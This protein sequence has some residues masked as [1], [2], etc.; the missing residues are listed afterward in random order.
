QLATYINNGYSAAEAVY[1]SDQV[2]L[3]LANGYDDSMFRWFFEGV[4]SAGAKWD[5]IGMSHYPPAASWASYNSQIS[6]TTSDMI[7]R[8]GKPV[9][10]SEVEMDWTQASTAK[11][12]LS[13]LISKTKAF[14][15]NGL[16]IFYW[17]PKA[18]PGW[19]S[20][21]LGAIDAICKFTIALQ[22]F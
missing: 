22:A 13:D 7:S 15:S 3:H 14:G 4:K 10:V 21:T 12:V 17:E 8:Y 16:G 20:Y 19:Q 9:I 18:Y 11:S 5:V 1:P 2:V 6:A